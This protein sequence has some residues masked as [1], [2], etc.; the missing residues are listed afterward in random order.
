MLKNIRLEFKKTSRPVLLT[1]A[2]LTMLTCVLTCTITREYALRFP[3]DAWE[4]GTEYIG[5]LFP[6]FVTIP[7]CWEL[8]YERKDRFIVYTLPRIGRQRYLSAKWCACAVSSFLILLVPYMLSALCA[9]YINRPERL[10]ATPEGY[11]HVF[12]EFY[13]QMPLAYALL[14]SLWKSLLG[15]L[16]MSFGF[17]LAM[18]GSNIFVILTAPFIYV[19]LENFLWAVLGL[20]EFRFVTA[21]EP[22]SVTAYAVQPASFFAGPLLLCC[23]MSLV[24]CYYRTVKKRSVYPV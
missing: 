19:I 1:T 22:T 17:I 12:H 23:V 11:R 20:P 7:I 9:L 2:L 8:Y 21:F 18:Y 3:I 6:L 24:V 16:V 4:V 10:W 13:T 15:V 14:L 5:L